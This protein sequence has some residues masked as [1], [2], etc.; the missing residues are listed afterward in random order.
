MKVVRYFFKF[1]TIFIIIQRIDVLLF[2]ILACDVVCE[3]KSKESPFRIYCDSSDLQTL[4]TSGLECV[5]S[6]IAKISLRVVRPFMQ[7]ALQYMALE[8][9]MS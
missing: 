5:S 2:T 7:I 4:F 6:F 8:L 1:I 3:Y 9:S